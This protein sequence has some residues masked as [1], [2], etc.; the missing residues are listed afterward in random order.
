ML[1]SFVRHHSTEPRLVASPK[2]SLVGL[3][4]AQKEGV[5]S[6]ASPP[7]GPAV[8]ATPK[9]RVAIYSNPSSAA[10]AAACTRLLTPNLP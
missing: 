1:L 6:G 10:R 9:S 2:G 8:E 4:V 3:F 5:V 7:T